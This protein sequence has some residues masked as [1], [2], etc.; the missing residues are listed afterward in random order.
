M[1][2]P[3]KILDKTIASNKFVKI[4]QREFLEKD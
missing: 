4:L 3:K 2:I 1:Y